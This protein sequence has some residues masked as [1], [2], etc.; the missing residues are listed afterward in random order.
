MYVTST[1]LKKVNAK[2][3]KPVS[4]LILKIS[5]LTLFEC[6]VKITL[7]ID[8]IYGEWIGLVL[9]T[10]KTCDN[11][12]QRDKQIEFIHRVTSNSV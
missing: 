7:D 2:I 8:P 10:Q 12:R 9:M 5:S 11:H 4:H 3:V 6:V 1:K